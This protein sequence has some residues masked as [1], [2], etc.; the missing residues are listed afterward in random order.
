M[1]NW[2]SHGGWFTLAKWKWDHWPP[3]HSSLFL[4]KSENHDK[5]NDFFFFWGF[6]WRGRYYGMGLFPIRMRCAQYS[7]YHY[8]RLVWTLCLMHRCV[9]LTIHITKLQLQTTFPKPLYIWHFAYIHQDPGHWKSWCLHNL[10]LL[11]SL[12]HRICIPLFLRPSRVNRPWPD[13]WMIKRMD[14]WMTGKMDEMML[15]DVLYYM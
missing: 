10:F 15:H 11:L 1:A 13:R 7:N 2:S 9:Y 4:C 8:I 12:S 14:G 3:I 5:Q 6:F